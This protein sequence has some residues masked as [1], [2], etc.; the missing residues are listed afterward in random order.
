[1]CGIVG[2]VGSKTAIN[3]VVNG[4]KRLEYRGYDS[5]GVATLEGGKIARRRSVGK[6]KNLEKNLEKTP[7][8]AGATM[9]IGH[10][11]WATHGKALECNAHPHIAKGVAVVHNGIIENYQMFREKLE[12]LGAV[13]TSQTDTET[14]PFNMSHLISQGKTPLEAV[15]ETVKEAEGA[16]AIG[17]I[18]EGEENTIIAARRNAPLVIGLGDGVN[19]LGSDAFALAPYTSDVIFLENDDIAVLTPEKVTIYTLD[20][21]E[22]QRAS[23]T[24]DVDGAMA[25]KGPFPNFMLKEIYE[26][27][28]VISATLS[29]YLNEDHTA[30]NL[31]K[32]PFDLTKVPQITIVACGTSWH[33][34]LIS[35]YWFERYARVPVNVDIASEFRY[36]MPPLLE[37]GLTILISQSGETADTLAAL[38]HA[39][40]EGQHILSIVNVRESSIDRASD[41][42]LYTQAGPEI[43]VASTKAFTTQL[44]LLATLA[45]FM[46]KEKQIILLDEFERMLAALKA[47]PADMNSLHM[48]DKRMQEVSNQLLEATSMLYLG[49]DSMF[50]MALEGALKMKEISYIHA[51]AYASGEM[52]HGPI[53]LID[54]TLPVVVL[55]PHDR[56]FEKSISNLQEVEARGGRTLLFTDSK[57]AAEAG[58]AENRTVIVMPA[59]S[60]FTAPLLYSLPMQLLAYHT[61]MKLGK[62]VDQPRNLAK[63]VT[64]E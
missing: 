61:A 49:R 17:A 51:E 42:S 37:G 15:R 10:T 4:L 47:V 36:R 39:Q 35:K 43:G 63:S 5:A 55:A 24:V 7:F 1:M 2:S 8:A 13:F 59:V 14:L 11:R 60:E 20:G 44:A 21:T 45:L 16:F 54:D 34:G 48:I 23:R 27:A 50:P 64:V 53:A 33:A 57:G 9:A 41:I 58:E 12:G 6:I 19:Y 38:E 30:M 62:D 46:A 26:Q 40:S 52:K 3:D 18:F 32:L 29:K 28:D 56:L 25:D 22:V 31:P